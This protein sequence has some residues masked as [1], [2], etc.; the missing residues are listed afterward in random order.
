MLT[1]RKVWV[2]DGVDRPDSITVQLL[3]DG[4][5]YDKVE[6]KQSNQWVYTWDDLSPKRTSPKSYC[7]RFSW[8][9]LRSS[10]SYTKN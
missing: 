3:R 9:A 7:P 8:D 2:D 10:D 4:E 6:L 5:V 1:V